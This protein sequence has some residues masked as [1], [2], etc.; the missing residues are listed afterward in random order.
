MEI[1]AAVEVVEEREEIKEVEVEAME[2]EH[3]VQGAEEH[4]DLDQVVEEDLEMQLVVNRVHPED[5]LLMVKVLEEVALLHP[6]QVV[7]QA[8]GQEDLLVLQEQEVDSPLIRML[9]AREAQAGHLV[10]E[11]VPLIEDLLVLPDQEV[12]SHLIKMLLEEVAQVDHPDPEGVLQVQGDLLLEDQL[13]PE[14]H[15]QGEGKVEVPLLRQVMVPLVVLKVD[16]KEDHKEDPLEMDL[17]ELELQDLV[18]KDHLEILSEQTL[19]MVHLQ[20]QEVKK[21]S[22]AQ[23]LAK[24][25]SVV[26]TLGKVDLMVPA[27]DKVVLEDQTLPTL[28]MVLQEVDLAKMVLGLVLIQEMQ[29]I[30]IW[31]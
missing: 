17:R 3:L 11:V 8:V 16:H 4:L 10:P 29:E 28:A 22:V 18:E 5:N 13:D 15:H 9:L 23:I 31:R 25:D 30:S 1:Q 2:E 6:A 24:E 21:A 12:A 20:G 27:L 26:Q 14:D 7:E 19:V